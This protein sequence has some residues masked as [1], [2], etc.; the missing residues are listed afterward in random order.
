MVRPALTEPYE[1]RTVMRRDRSRHKIWVV[2][3][4][5]GIALVPAFAFASHPGG[6]VDVPDDHTFHDDIAWMQD[7]GVTR[8]CNPPANDEFCPE[9][10]LTRG[11]E[12][13]FFH[14][15]DRFLRDSLEERLLPEECEAGQTA[16]FDGETWNC[17]DGAEAG[18]GIYVASGEAVTVA[19]GATEDVT[20]ACEEGDTALSGA[21]TPVQANLTFEIAI[22]DGEVTASVTN[23]TG[24]DVD[25]TAHA[26]CA[27]ATD[28][29][30][31]TTVPET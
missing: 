27:P 13:A 24:A 26:I 11:E 28:T 17:V 18:T 22:S 15:Y 25:V 29:P 23:A 30:P 19:D 5:L 2:G 1:R 10:G 4:A 31:P 14:R 20:A 7:N 9:R 16:E 3:L 6:F 12:A 21:I 8:G